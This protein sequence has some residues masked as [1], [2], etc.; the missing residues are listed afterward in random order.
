[1]GNDT[2]TRPTIHQRDLAKLPR[3]LAPLIERPQWGVWRWTQLPN[4]KWQ[5]PPFVAAQP[6]RHASTSDPSTWTDYST[7]LAAV[8]AGHGDGISYILTENDPFAAIDIDNCRHLTTHSIDLWAQ[9][10]MQFAVTSYQEVTPSGEGVRIWGL[11]NGAA[12]NKKFTLQ[13][14][15]KD[16]AVELFRCTRKALTITGYRLDTVRELTNIDRVLDW[17]V[18]WGE[19]RKAAAAAAA[20]VNGHSFDSNG[21][22]YSVDQIEQIVRTGAPDGKNRS[23]TFHTIVGHYVGCSWSEE[24]IS[25][26]LQQF[27]QGIGER[28]LGENRLRREVERSVKAF[29]KPELPLSGDHGGGWTGKAP[30]PEQHQEPPQ[31]EPE[32]VDPRSRR[33]RRAR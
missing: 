32:D 28:Y 11:A 3:A 6:Q 24:Q 21:S 12:L 29:A 26:H 14:N 31:E 8:Q 19:R 10:F 1:M 13:I 9:L 30:P 7:A 27:P 33:R 22:G 18:I 5:K 25:E 20:P 16:V 2:N 15:E 23:N 4:G 17:G